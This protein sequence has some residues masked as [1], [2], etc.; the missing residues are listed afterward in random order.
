MKA[1][2]LTLLVI[3]CIGLSISLQAQQL[4]LTILKT[5]EDGGVSVSFD[6]GEYEGEEIDKVNDDDLDMGWEGEDLNI[7]TTY[8]RFQ[9]VTIPKGATIDSARLYIYAHEDESAE[10]R[11]NI[12]AE[13]ADNSAPFGEEGKITDRKWTTAKLDWDIKDNWTMWKPYHSP[14]I[15]SVI[16]EVVN[17][18][19]WV[20]GN[21]LTVF[22]QGEDQGASLLDNARDFESFENIEDPADGGDGKH[23]PERI[24]VLK[25]Y[26]STNTAV[27][28]FV[29]DINYLTVY[30]NPVNNGQLHIILHDN[31]PTSMSIF[32]MQGK[33]VLHK[34]ICEQQV[35]L[36]I[37]TLNKGI[38]LIKAVQNN[39]TFVQKI[40]VR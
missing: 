31:A 5:G 6:D 40:V 17:R 34:E 11:I 8:L 25:V 35:T 10:A 3:L 39:S 32:D 13:A 36:D 24:P 27:D 16:Q 28:E 38:Y 23:H 33:Q 12:Y 9:N 30:P 21:A 22:L 20:S 2:L 4:T 26:Y 7:M 37:Q 15:K 19:G 29:A 1:R 14:D 18:T